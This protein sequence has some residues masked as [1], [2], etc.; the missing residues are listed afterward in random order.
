MSLDYKV[1]NL[2]IPT[3]SEVHR[4][5]IQSTQ[6][7]SLRESVP[8]PDIAKTFRSSFVMEKPNLMSPAARTTTY[9]DLVSN[10][11]SKGRYHHRARKEMKTRIIL[12]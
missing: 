4:S 8:L 6:P 5:I 12:D 7:S 11:V 1:K 10:T 2:N 3:S 9:Q